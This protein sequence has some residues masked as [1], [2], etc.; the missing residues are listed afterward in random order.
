MDDWEADE[1][2]TVSPEAGCTASWCT[3]YLWI[4]PARVAGTHVLPQGEL[5]LKQKFQV[6][7]GTLAAEGKTY[8]IEG[9]VRGRAVT[10]KAG[11]KTYRGKMN[12][13]R[14]ELS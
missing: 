3:A 2:Q 10:L 4:V 9:K 14:L 13:S 12:G 8:V 6:L 5:V 11:G 1:T 7:S